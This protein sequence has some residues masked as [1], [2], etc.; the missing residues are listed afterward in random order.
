MLPLK[1]GLQITRIV[2]SI[3]KV[4]KTGNMNFLTKQAYKFLY[5]SSGFIAHYDI[6]GFR[7][8]YRDINK[9][10]S[11]IVG[12]QEFN[13]WNNFMPYDKD[14]SYYEQK[15]DIYNRICDAIRSI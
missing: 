1:S 11:D 3:V 6:H 5:L 2:N 4:V 13:Q 15:Q 7:Q 8:Y 12:F 10:I 14:Y 9:L